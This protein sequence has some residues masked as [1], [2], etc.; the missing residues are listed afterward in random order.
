M[1]EYIALSI[2]QNC[3]SRRSKTKL[4]R[5]RLLVNARRLTQ[6]PTGVR[7]P[8]FTSH[9]SGRVEQIVRVVF[10]LDAP[11]TFQV[12]PIERLQRV[13]LAE[14]GFIQVRA[15]A[16]RQLHPRRIDHLCQQLLSRLHRCDGS[17]PIP[18]RVSNGVQQRV[19]PGW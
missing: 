9:G 15:R 16:G 6:P 19:A 2:V 3:T 13:D 12:I 8:G 14:V 18:R 10:L 5:N 4:S 11:K 17:A 7:H 1:N